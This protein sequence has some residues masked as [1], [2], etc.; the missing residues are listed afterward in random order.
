M[1][2]SGFRAT[3]TGLSNNIPISTPRTETAVEVAVL[4]AFRSLS[5]PLD[6]VDEALLPP[7]LED[8]TVHH[9]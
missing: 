7:T 8:F 9:F 1:L 2:K 4:L 6:L 3:A 5:A